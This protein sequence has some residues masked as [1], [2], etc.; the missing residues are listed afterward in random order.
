MGS[1]DILRGLVARELAARSEPWARKLLDA[2]TG[3]GHPDVVAALARVAA[4]LERSEQADALSE[5]SS[6]EGLVAWLVDTVIVD[7]ADPKT[8]HRP[9]LQTAVRVEFEDRG[10]EQPSARAMDALAE[11]VLGAREQSHPRALR[12]A[13]PQRA[14]EEYLRGGEASLRPAVVFDA[15]ETIAVES[16]PLTAGAAPGR[17]APTR[18]P[19][20]TPGPTKRR[21]AA[22][23]KAGARRK[24]K[25]AAKKGAV[26]ARPRRAAKP[27][28]RKRTAAR[29]KKRGVR[30]A[31]RA[32]TRRLAKH[33]RRKKK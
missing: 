20:G 27:P 24:R 7:P 31:G 4:G 19:A 22:R 2:A 26:R 30:R 29:R 11:L 12:L 14:V 9:Q 25:P 16:M 32:V 23:A 3:Q 8:A 17:G 6:R 33:A 28:G 10:G 13:L 15:T 5:P 18:R 1:G 21:P